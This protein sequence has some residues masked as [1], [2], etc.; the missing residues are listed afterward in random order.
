MRF[1]IKL[2][3]ISKVSNYNKNS[4]Q[5][6]I[7]KTNEEFD[8]LIK[9][10]SFDLSEL[11]I[12]NFK[13]EGDC[14]LFIWRNSNPVLTVLKK[15]E[16]GKKFNND[17]FR[18]YLAGLIQKIEKDNF[19]SLY[20]NIPKHKEY[21]EFFDN[22]GYFYQTF[23]EGILLG[24]YNFDHY[25]KDKKK[26]QNLNVF[27]IV[28][29][30]KLFQKSLIKAEKIISGVFFT[31]DLVNE[32]A[33][34]L[35]P[36]E[37]AKRV[38]SEFRNSKVSIKIFDE[39]ELH[40]RKMNAIL[41]V[42]KASDNKPKLIVAHYKPRSKSNYKIA[43]VGKGVTYDTGGLSI[44]PTK[45]MLEM[46]AD[47]A[48]GGTVFGIL[49]AAEKLEIPFEIYGIV[50]AVENAISGNA[51]KPGDIISTSTGKT[52]EVK[53]TD[54]EG[55]I[56]LADALEFA[57]QL[58]PDE[59][60]DFATLTG[61]VAV[62]LGLFTS[63]L[64]TK[65]DKISEQLIKASEQT[66]EHIWQLP[67]WDEYNKLL[68]SKIADISNLGPRWGGAITAGKFLEFFVDEKIPW[69]HIDLAGPALE[70]ELT[71]YSK[72][73]CTGYGVRLICKYLE[74]LIK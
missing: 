16:I 18:N 2:K 37:F 27:F 74:D 14:E 50:P 46:K 21:S 28:N 8:T 63:G 69:A 12:N 54:A 34:S 5:V 22:E 71:N 38:K 11:Q 59:I 39:K 65:N 32:P 1:N 36:A 26:P 72:D 53:D 35:T 24:N 67:F 52:I 15:T 70:H 9:S 45:G 66:Y 4:A 6:I 61:A 48:G 62:A 42:G 56:I 13:K 64:F 19:S 44:K 7:I 40:K 55:R 47:M 49:K 51:Y 58:K 20:I 10:E 57:S 73:Y 29:N 60:I 31:R 17:Y 25:K 23:C 3:V 41:S 68:E 30:N 43:L 33:N